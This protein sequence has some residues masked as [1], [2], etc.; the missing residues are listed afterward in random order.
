M[1]TGNLDV[2]RRRILAAGP[3]ALAA[4]LLPGTP[5]LA[6]DWPSGPIRVIVP[7]PAGGGTDG[8]A[9]AVVDRL[10]IQMQRPFVVENRPGAGG[11]IA[12]ESVASSPAD[13]T[14]LF[15]AAIPQIA[16]LPVLQSV[17]YD[18]QRDFTPI[19]NLATSP[20]ILA[21]RH[22]LPARTVPELVQ[23]ARSKPGGLTYASGSNG[24]LTHIAAAVF[25]KRAGVEILH[26]PFQGG[27]AAMAAL[28]A[29]T[30][31]MY[32]AN[33]SEAIAQQSSPRIRILGVSSPQR[34]PQL[35]AVPTIAD[36]LAGYEVIVWTGL[37]APARMPAARVA[38]LQ[39]Q[40][41]RAVSSA[42][43]KAYFAKSG[44]V[45]VGSTA[46]EFAE[47]IAGD[48][49]LYRRLIPENDIRIDR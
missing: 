33:A 39:E 36:T 31:D 49:A 37:F 10:G 38:A 45:P 3:A 34:M 28:L 35:P 16:V 20:F 42:E 21:V 8:I 17:R 11:A 5:A 32:F 30:V 22:D 43:V 15:V 4:A 14:V 2:K 7:F 18:P 27:A 48:V 29:G 26:V 46:A 12:A 47:T 23:L 40:A 9:R 6:N 41:V 25:A 19:S 44:V 24:S 1:N 13:G